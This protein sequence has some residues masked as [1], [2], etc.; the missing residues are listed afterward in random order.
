MAAWRSLRTQLW[1]NQLFAL[2]P[3]KRGVVDVSRAARPALDALLL[4]LVEPVVALRDAAALEGAGEQDSV[5]LVAWFADQVMLHLPDQY[6]K[7][8]AWL[9]L[10]ILAPLAARQLAPGR[11]AL[12]R[13]GRVRVLDLHP[14]RHLD[15]AGA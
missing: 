3:R 12:G 2:G 10:L 8:K 1:A 14:F 13:L 9:V 4:A 5:A 7:V 11:V 15:R 6:P